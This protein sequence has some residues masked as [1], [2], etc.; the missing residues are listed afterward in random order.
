MSIDKPSSLSTKSS[1]SKEIAKEIIDDLLTAAFI[2]ISHMD[3]KLKSVALYYDILKDALQDILDVYDKPKPSN[4]HSHVIAA[5]KRDKPAKLSA[6]DSL[7]KNR[8]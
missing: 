2:Q 5:W 6:P 7:I 3:Y 8:L 4:D 1:E